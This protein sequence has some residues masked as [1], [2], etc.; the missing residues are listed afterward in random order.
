MGMCGAH[1][2][3]HLPMRFPCMWGMVRTG[4]FAGVTGPRPLDDLLGG[5]RSETR[6][7]QQKKG[8]RG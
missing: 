7:G 3:I 8:V 5:N 2:L 6:G 1:G 4:A